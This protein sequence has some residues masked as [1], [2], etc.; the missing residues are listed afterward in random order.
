MS[1]TNGLTPAEEAILAFEAGF[2]SRAGAKEQA[3]RDRF[4]TSPTHY[5]QQLNLLIDNPA[6]LQASP[7]LVRRLRAVRD[8]RRAARGG[9]GS[10]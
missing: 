3:I 4:G 5:Y 2:W 1:N 8:A 7:A 10:Q 9:V 6:A